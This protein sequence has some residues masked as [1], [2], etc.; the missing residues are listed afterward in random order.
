M[1]PNSRDEHVRPRRRGRLGPLLILLGLIAACTHP[2]SEFGLAPPDPDRSYAAWMR[3][4]REARVRGDY[5]SATR[6]AR[7]AIAMAR[8]NAAPYALIGSLHEESGFPKKAEA[9]YRAA[10]QVDPSFRPARVDLGWLLL[11]E[12]RPDAAAEILPEATRRFEELHLE[13]AVLIAKGDIESGSAALRKA[14]RTADHLGGMVDEQALADIEC[15]L[16][17][18]GETDRNCPFGPVRPTSS[19]A[20]PQS[21]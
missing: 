18:L 1:P 13:G 9:A 16:E 10:I 19:E 2:G 7:H 12:G 6:Q 15:R 14:K 17:A 20:P 5:E 11:R 4:A 8:D 3:S 21:G